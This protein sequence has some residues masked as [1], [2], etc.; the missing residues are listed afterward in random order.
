MFYK[1]DFPPT[2]EELQIEAWKFMLEAL[3][4]G[5]DVSEE[6]KQEARE[7]YKKSFGDINE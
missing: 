6:V 1:V 3:M 4:Y 2:Q 7:E 5:E